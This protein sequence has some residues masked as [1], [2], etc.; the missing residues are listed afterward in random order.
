MATKTENTAVTLA[1]L[2]PDMA[3]PPMTADQLERETKY[4]AA[5]ALAKS[6]LARGV[7]DADDFARIKARFIEKFSPPFGPLLR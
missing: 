5:I 7:I 1:M 2:R 6:M 4:R 3:R